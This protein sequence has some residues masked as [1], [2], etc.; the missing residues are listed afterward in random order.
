MSSKLDKISR[1]ADLEVKPFAML[2]AHSVPHFI[3]EARNQCNLS[4]EM[5]IEDAYP[6]TDLQEGF[7]ASTVKQPG[8][9]VDKYVYQI[10]QSVDISRFKVAWE[11]TIA[12][13]TNLRTR[14]I[15][16]EGSTMQVVIKENTSWEWKHCPDLAA[17][18]LAVQGLEMT[19]G[20]RLCQYTIAKDPENYNYFIWAMHHAIYDGWSMRLTIETLQRLYYFGDSTPVLHSHA[21]FVRYTKELDLVNAAKYWDAQLKHAKRC[22]FPLPKAKIGLV[23]QLHQPR[24]HMRKEIALLHHNRAAIT[25]GNL[26]RAAW[27]IV[28][29]RY[30]D[31][32][33]V[34]FG[35]TVSDR[36]APIDGL[37]RI[38]GPVLAILPIRARFE[39]DSTVKGFLQQIQK[40][41]FEMVPYEQFGLQRI[42]KLSLDAKEA[43]SFSSL[44]IIQPA[45]L[46]KM[47]EVDTNVILESMTDKQVWEGHQLASHSDYALLLQ[48]HIHDKHWEF[49]ASY[50]S[51]VLAETQVT[52]LFHHFDRAVQQLLSSGETLLRDVSLAGPWDLQQATVWNGDGPEI[53]DDCVHSMIARQAQQRPDAP[54]IYAWNGKLTYSELNAAADRL[55]RHLV[56]KLDVIAEV[57]V[58]V[59]FEKSV[60]FFVAILAINKAGGA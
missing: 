45:S 9:Y 59:C 27:A 53:I 5:L 52:A 26:F 20:S 56:E 34:C 13:C 11:A 15:V 7:M 8:S 6:C 50:D 51:G 22:A 57:L 31:S 3:S 37:D 17:S 32:D 25:E 28:L 39:K 12:M 41:A 18:L 16:F 33:D 4:D 55:A 21:R 1:L 10:P 46:T 14:I 43:C 54:A 35:T 44:L 60:W 58:H 48:L 24:A 47:L 38:A 19:Y 42:A 30:S 29:A 36:R 40:Q 2:R 49:H 23:Q